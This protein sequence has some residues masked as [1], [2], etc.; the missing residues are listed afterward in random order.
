MDELSASACC[1]FEGHA[2]LASAMQKTTRPRV[3]FMIK[4]SASLSFS[5]VAAGGTLGLA[6]GS[7]RFE[8]VSFVPPA[9]GPAGGDSPF[10]KAPSSERILGPAR[11]DAE[12]RAR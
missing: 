5:A 7:E 8:D 1:A 10:C 9:G 6:S 12:R 3:R 2:R 11:R 4:L